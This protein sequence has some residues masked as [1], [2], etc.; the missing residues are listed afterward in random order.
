MSDYSHIS[1]HEMRGNQIKANFVHIFRMH[2]LCCGR[3][4]EH[5]SSRCIYMQ[6][7]VMCLVALLHKIYILL[8][9]LLGKIYKPAVMIVI[10]LKLF[11]FQIQI[12][13]EII[14]MIHHQ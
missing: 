9:Y 6:T 11:Y 8:F 10:Y 4:T 1:T 2:S 7:N 14:S 12:G 3:F 5:Q 13:I